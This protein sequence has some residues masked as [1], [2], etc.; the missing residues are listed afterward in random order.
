[1]AIYPEQQYPGKI[2]PSNADY[3]FASAKNV[4]LPNSGDGFPL[5]KE[6][7][8]D[9]LGWEQALLKKAG[10]SPSGKADTARNSQYLAAMQALCGRIFKSVADLS[11]D[12][13]MVGGDFALLTRYYSNEEDESTGVLIF[14]ANTP[15][16]AHDGVIFF[17][18]TVPIGSGIDYRAGVGETEP[19]G[20]GVWRL[21]DGFI[22]YNVS[23]N[24]PT[25]APS[26]NVALDLVRSI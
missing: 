4:S 7:I 8:N 21:V 5:E 26:I 20:K 18:P 15:K 17:S 3:P 23:L 6:W 12:Q 9:L 11:R 16:S 10:I 25:Q 1:M 14:E 13:T 24:V 2:N 22:S 19:T